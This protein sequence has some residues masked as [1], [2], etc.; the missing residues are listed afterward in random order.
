MGYSG[1]SHPFSSFLVCGLMGQINGLLVGQ[2]ERGAEQEVEAFSE[3][4]KILQWLS[5]PF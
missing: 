5:L 3:A 2:R 4:P 1:H